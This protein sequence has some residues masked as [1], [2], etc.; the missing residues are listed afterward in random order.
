[1]RFSALIGERDFTKIEK[2]HAIVF[3]IGGVGSAAIEA[4]AR[5]GV[6]TLT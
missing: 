2:T 3:G 6:G 5:C 4:L 1:M